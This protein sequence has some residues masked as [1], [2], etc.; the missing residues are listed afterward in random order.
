M[1]TWSLFYQHSFTQKPLKCFYICFSFIKVSVL[2]DFSF[3]SFVLLKN[4]LIHQTTLSILNY[5]SFPFL[6]SFMFSLTLNG[7][8]GGAFGAP[9]VVFRSVA[10]VTKKVMGYF[11]FFFRDRTFFPPCTL[12]YKLKKIF[13]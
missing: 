5:F 3:L 12:P 1:P 11:R 8:G 4:M 2:E 7:L 9:P 13:F 6:S 10:L